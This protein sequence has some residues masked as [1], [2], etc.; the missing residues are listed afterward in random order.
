MFCCRAA[1]QHSRCG[2]RKHGG[3]CLSTSY[4][5]VALFAAPIARHAS[6][7]KQ[8]ACCVPSPP[9]ARRFAARLTRIAP[10]L[11]TLP[12]P[13]T[14]SLLAPSFMPSLAL[15]PSSLPLS[16]L[17]RTAGAPPRIPKRATARIRALRV[18]GKQNFVCRK[19]RSC[20]L[21]FA[22]SNNNVPPAARK[23]KTSQHSMASSFWRACTCCNN[24]NVL[25]ALIA[26]QHARN[27]FTR[28]L[29]PLQRGITS[30]ASISILSCISYLPRAQKQGRG[31][32]QRTA[33]L[34]SY[35]LLAFGA[36]GIR[37]TPRGAR[38]I[39]RR[40]LHKHSAATWR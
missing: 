37:P 19:A 35:S 26:S 31:A 27:I 4:Q 17:R 3:A 22:G 20:L 13:F 25:C 8:L 33:L 11:D 29:P 21:F 39:E 1:A 34:F 10:Y 40:T 30:G 16:S 36:R 32:Q 14:P 7:L 9:L 24:H 18:C 15:L 38:A 2:A 23:L 6:R 12:S 28:S 5:L